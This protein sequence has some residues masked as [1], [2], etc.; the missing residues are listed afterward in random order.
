MCMYCVVCRW[1][2]WLVGFCFCFVFGFV[3]VVVAVVLALLLMVA[4]V[5]AR[6]GDYGMPAMWLDQ[7]A[8]SAACLRRSCGEENGGASIRRLPGASMI[9]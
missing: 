9:D 6:G 7:V 3:G 8:L 1:L 2:R 4:I 5:M